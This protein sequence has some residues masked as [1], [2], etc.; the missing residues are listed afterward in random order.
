MLYDNINYSLDISYLNNIFIREYDISKAN[1]NILY[2]KRVIT[3]E[4]YD[5]LYNA[6]RMVR[7]KYVGMLQKDKE[8]M[9][10]LKAGIIEAKKYLFEA[11]NIQ[12][13]EVLSIKNDAVFIINR[14]LVNTNFGLI[15]F[16][17]KNTYTSF[18]KIHNL[19]LYYYY[20][21][22]NKHEVLDVKGIGCDKLILHDQYMLQLLKDV[23]YSVQVSGIEV[24][25][26]LLK[27]FYMSYINLTL[28]VGYYRKFDVS[29][30]YH[31]SLNTFLGTGFETENIED[32]DK[33]YLDITYNL[34]IILELQKILTSIYFTK[35]KSQ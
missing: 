6:E 26:R 17:N 19:E 27:D 13:Y 35:Y 4:V 11:N 16:L 24:A 34:S 30:N 31:Y 28:D 15:N 3:K 12:D 8:I 1:I 32:K 18:Y 25:M 20:N 29:S 10:I 7:Q 22:M 33:K 9:E 21:N 2:S 23:F 5:Y 14:K